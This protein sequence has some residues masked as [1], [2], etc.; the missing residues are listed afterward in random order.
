VKDDNVEVS[1]HFF[2]LKLTK[3]DLI[4]VLKALQN[5][6]I[7]T[8]PHNRQIVHNG[9]PPEVQALVDGLGTQSTSASVVKE[10]LSTGVELIAKPSGLHVPPWQLVSAELN[11]VS[12]RA[13]T[14]WARPKIPSTTEST[15][16]ACWDQSV[17]KPGAVEIATSGQWEGTTFGLKGGDGPDFNHAK[18]GVSISGEHPYA[19]F[20]DMNQQ[21]TLSGKNCKSS[22]N[23]RGGLF[24]VLDNKAL[25]DGVTNLIG[26]DTAPTN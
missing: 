21:G 7:V 9:G 6:S 4:K 11:G 12:L 15:Q 8:D 16:I 1:Q 22:Q 14:W 5:A 2:A 26:G 25:F 19:I 20:G 18:I 13:A 23:G 24:Y 17:G 10:T 3:D